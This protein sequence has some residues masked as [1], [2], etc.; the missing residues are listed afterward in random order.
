MNRL[1]VLCVEHR[2]QYLQEMRSV[3]QQ[4]GYDVVCATTGSQAMFE[5]SRRTF[6]GVLL[7]YDLPDGSGSLLRDEMMRMK[8]KLPIILITGGERQ[9]S[10]LLRFFESFILHPQQ[11]RKQPMPQ[12]EEMGSAMQHQ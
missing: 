1:T 9:I 8:P 7:E 6:D 12:S 4:A 3:L 11:E 5:F 2:S 10:F